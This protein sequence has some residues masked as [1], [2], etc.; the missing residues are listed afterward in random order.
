[1][2]NAL[3][4]RI[5]EGDVQT[6]DQVGRKWDVILWDRVLGYLDEADVEKAIRSLKDSLAEDGYPSCV[7]SSV[8]TTRARKS[9]G[10]ELGSS[11]AKAE[12]LVF[13]TF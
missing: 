10:M 3:T 7:R 5:T 2:A 13:G 11:S 9:V 12:G 1:V 8:L 6:L 4:E